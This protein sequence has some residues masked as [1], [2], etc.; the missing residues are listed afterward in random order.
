MIY[1]Q[2]NKE[3]GTSII[4]ILNKNSAQNTLLKR[5][6]G[7]LAILGLRYFN[8]KIISKSNIFEKVSIKD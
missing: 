6:N 5:E 4:N 1:F 2:I 8:L 7:L 3:H